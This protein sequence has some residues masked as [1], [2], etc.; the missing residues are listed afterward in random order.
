LRIAQAAISTTRVISGS[1]R[2]S[3]LGSITPPRSDSNK[4]AYA[5]VAKAMSDK[6]PPVL[7]NARVLEYAVLGES[8]TYSG[9]S[10]L[11]VGKENEGLK[12]L[13][14]VPRLA[15]AED[16]KTGEVMLLHCDEEWDLLGV[17]GK[18]D[19]IAKVKAS[20]ERAYRGVS[21]CWIDGKISRDEALRFRDEMWTGQRCS[22]CNR[23]PPDFN[24]MVERNNVRICDLCVAEFQKI[25]AEEPQSKE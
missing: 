15:I 1:S 18:Y 5:T 14:P 21:S 6:P 17:G 23:T 20:A 7:G 22:F 16:L 2:S 19:S 9:H 25:L 13:G 3:I 8:V 11:F 4:V 24:K 12:E 10:S